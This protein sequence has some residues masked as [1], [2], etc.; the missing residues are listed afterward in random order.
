MPK[1]ID[2]KKLNNGGGFEFAYNDPLKAYVLEI[3]DSETI[4]PIYIHDEAGLYKII[5][6]KTGKLQMCK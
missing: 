1:Q 3:K 2:G 5:K 6:T 4:F